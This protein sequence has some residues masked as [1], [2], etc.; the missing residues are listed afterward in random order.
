V[1]NT[2]GYSVTELKA[3]TGALVQV[4]SGSSYGFVA[5][6]AISS[7]G[8]DVWVANYDGQSVSVFPT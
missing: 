6:Y 4:I 1:A 7:D 5:P 2:G 8:S 3:P